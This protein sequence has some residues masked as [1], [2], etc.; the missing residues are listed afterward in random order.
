MMNDCVLECHLDRNHA[1]IEACCVH[2][3]VFAILS[4]Y[5]LIRFPHPPPHSFPTQQAK[6]FNEFPWLHT[7]DNREK[8]EEVLM[9]FGAREGLFLVRAS[10]SKK[11]VVRICVI[12][13]CVVR[14]SPGL[15]DACFYDILFH[16]RS[17]ISSPWSHTMS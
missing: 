17:M 4:P 1:L 3:C 6:P 15:R 2:A 14:A 12:V 16:H 10:G 5:H 8:A 9:R 7:I 11:C 13:C